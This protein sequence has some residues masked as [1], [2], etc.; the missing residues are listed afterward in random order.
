MIRDTEKRHPGDVITHIQYL[1]PMKK[2]KKKNQICLGFGL[3]LKLLHSFN[4]KVIY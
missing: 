2:Q 4:L 3:T 1:K